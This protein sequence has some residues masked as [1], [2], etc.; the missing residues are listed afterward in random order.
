MV[1][2][3]ALQD[4]VVPVFQEDPAV[5]VHLK[6]AALVGVKALARVD[7]ANAD[8]CLHVR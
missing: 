6:V 4:Q 3:V 2:E 8:K 7:P 5:L 1:P